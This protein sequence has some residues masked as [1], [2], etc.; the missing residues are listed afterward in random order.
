MFDLPGYRFLS[1]LHAGR[2]F[3]IDRG[4]RLIDD[5]PVIIKRLA[6]HARSEENLNRLQHEYNLLREL[7]IPGVVQP[8]EYRAEALEPAVVFA[9]PGGVPA[10]ELLLAR[11][12]S[13]HQWLPI[14]IHL[15]ETLGR[16]HR[17]GVIHRQLN[18][19][20]L[21][22]NPDTQT[23]TLVNFCLATGAG[24]EPVTGDLAPLS[25]KGLPYIAPEQTGRINRSVDY[26]TDFYSFGATLYQ[27]LSHAPPFSADDDLTLLHSHIARHPLP[28]HRL[29]PAL[30][31]VLSRITLKLLAKDN[32]QRYLSSFGLTQDLR[33][34]YRCWMETASIP[35]FS[36]AAQDI[37]ERFEIPQTLY[38]RESTIERLQQLLQRRALSGQGATTGQSRILTA[39]ELVLISGYA[40]VG[41]TSLVQEIQQSIQLHN[42]RFVRGKF[43]PFPSPYSGFLKALRSLIRQLLA[44]PEARVAQWRQKLDSTLGTQAP[45]MVQMLPELGLLMGDGQVGAGPNRPEDRHLPARLFRT[46]LQTFATAEQPLVLLLDDL[47][48]ADQASLNL[49]QALTQ[50][51][52]RPSLLLI[53]SYRDNEVPADHP[54]R[55]LLNALQR[56][57]VQITEIELQPLPL[58]QVTR[59][60]ADTLCCAPSACAG[61]AKICLDKTQGNPFFL[62][63]FLISLHDSGLIRFTGE[64]WHWDE[65]QIRE[66]AITDNVVDL[67]LQK[68]QRLTRQTRD[69]LQLAAGIGS[70]FDLHTLAVVSERSLQQA[71]KDLLP[72]LK[73]GLV[74]PLEEPLHLAREPGSGR[75]GYRFA[76]DRVHQAAYALVAAD[77]RQ[78]LHLQI[79]RMMQQNLNRAESD[80]RTFEITNHFNLARSLLSTHGE[81]L[82]LAHLNLKAG[83]RA[84]DAAAFDA[85]S[86][87]LQRGLDQ[88]PQGGWRSHYALT[89]ELHHAAIEVAYIRGDYAALEPLAAEVLSQAVDLLDQVPVYE[90]RI[91]SQVA[92]NQF[93][94]ALETALTVLRLLGVDLPESP[95]R[96]RTGA[97][98]MKIRW[99]LRRH[100]PTA[101]LGAARMKDRRMLAATSI[102]VSMFGAIKFSSSAL[103]TLVMAKQVELCLR[104][105]LTPVSAQVFAGYAGVLCGRV[106]TVEQGY[107]LG[108]LALQLDQREPS[109]SR[110]Q[111]TL[112]LF[113]TYVRH[114]KE[115]LRASCESLL[116]GY[117][118]AADNGDMEW[119]AYCL[120]A[121]IQFAFLQGGDL[122]GLQ[123]RFDEHV[124]WL[125]RSGQK[126][127]VQY[128]LFT[129]Q[130]IDNLRYPR[131][132]PTWLDG[133]YYQEDFMMAE[134]RAGNHRTAIC[135]HHFYKALLGYLFGEIDAAVAHCDA[136]RPYL[137]YIGG[138]YTFAFHPFLD[139]LC[140]LAQ[141]PGLPPRQ[142]GPALRRVRKGI[143]QLNNWARHCPHNHRHHL[144]LLQAELDAARGRGAAA[145]DRYDEAI[146]LARDNGFP[147]VEALANERAGV[148]HLHKDRTAVAAA[149]LNEARRC[150][151]QLGAEAKREQLEDA[152]PAVFVPDP[153]GA[154]HARAA[155]SERQPPHSA[156]LGFTNQTI[157]IA[158]V[159][160]ASQAISDEI[161]LERLLARLMKLV[162]ENVG[163]QRA[164]LVLKRDQRLWLEAEA[165]VDGEVRFFSGQ[166]LHTSDRLPVSLVQYVARTQETL[167]LD[168]SRHQDMLMQDSYI[169]QQRPCSLLCAPVVYQGNLS[170]VL[171]LENNDNRDVFQ[172]QRVQILHVLLAQAAISIENA[173][174]YQSL[175]QSEQ[176][177]RS[178]FEN[179]IEGIF[180]SSLEGRFISVNP[181]LAALLGYDSAPQ[182][183]T[184][185]K[186]IGQQCFADQNDLRQLRAALTRD[187]R[188][189]NFETR[190]SRIDGSPV[191]VSLSIRSVLDDGGALRYYEGSVTDISERRARDEAELAQKAAHLA[192]EKAEAA[193]QA[194]SQFLATMSH[195]I[196]TPMNGILGMAQLLKR[197]AL[198]EEQRAQV[199][200]LQQSGQAL[201][202]ILNDV[203][204]LAKIESGQ[205]ELENAP[206][207]LDDWL[208]EVDTILSPL[209]AA[210]GLAFSLDRPTEPI[211]PVTGDRR[212]LN[213]ILMNLGTNAIKFTEQ[214][215]IHLRVRFQQIHA[216]RLGLQVTV[217]DSGIG[218]PESV[219]GRI[220]QD[221]SQ[222]DSSITRR[223]GGTGLGLSICRQLV[224]LHQGRIG[225]ESQVG[226]GSRFWF[227]IDYPTCDPA[228]CNQ[229]TPPA[230]DYAQEP[231][232]PLRVLL[233]EDTQI[234][235]QVAK[236]LLAVDG[237]RVW[238]AA[239]GHQALALHRNQTF[240]LVLMDIHLPGMDGMETTRALRQHP[241]PHKA[242][243]PVIALTASMTTDE[244]KAYRAAGIDRVLGKPL[245]LD[246]LRQ[247]LNA[248]LPPQPASGVPPEPPVTAPLLSQTSQPS[249]PAQLPRRRASAGEPE[250]SLIDQALLAQHRNT[251]G[252][253]KFEALLAT[254][255]RQCQELFSGLDSALAANDRAGLCGLAHKLAGAGANFGLRALAER[256]KEIEASASNAKT[257]RLA[258]KISQA[259][260]VYRT[261]RAQL[262]RAGALTAEA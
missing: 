109:P 63:Q 47:H 8:L 104:H 69:A 1:Q 60:V 144:V 126:Q 23:A 88:L 253:E 84:R 168:D 166:S 97:G 116:R 235:Q 241:D 252:A 123:Q 200:T 94:A 210:K 113:D 238:T 250:Q 147:L 4:L 28:P 79:A 55:S 46:L 114:W 129:L 206:F 105:G 20:N 186:D 256:C 72:A 159:V 34:C 234:N 260:E 190:W 140:R 111:R 150:Y 7:E 78:T 213:Q 73:E 222:A 215:G 10:S 45:L 244:V 107:A 243:I 201:L 133:K 130:V 204:D 92:R 67:L 183:L 172:A 56:A 192:R 181:A 41:K 223:Y 86:D 96:Q 197:G 164:L 233:V 175:T 169:K 248:A 134:H 184:A 167:L 127:S 12:C 179:A 22:I 236:A 19:S 145:I 209:A 36:I 228:L 124:K 101:I 90:V 76:H 163:A 30:P 143:R 49:I 125:R 68:M 93:S 70:Q 198:S 103:R 48:W 26:R 246:A 177:F 24:D 61:L 139:G 158:S 43:D 138:T 118:L 71:A 121:H 249:Q 149:Y 106:K 226:K 156:P 54:L 89:L 59:L 208:D 137:P 254:L 11:R 25:S 131:P 229:P 108:Q 154:A 53:A 212:S 39:Q 195:E 29:N 74:A 237:H 66:Q 230:Q 257:S 112:Y 196:R 35:L 194:K 171:Y 153:M 6:P 32:A 231:V 98:V 50:G 152:H 117:R 17:A 33:H 161:V 170:A 87:Y 165:E 202:G 42:G 81:R 180:R 214:G 141:L 27:M 119:G 157:D 239:D 15:S 58:P 189:R 75:Q 227:E 173:T 146:A 259:R 242:A 65:A 13:W 52:Q 245:L 14:V 57:P 38:G 120:A 37:S 142:R 182:F 207:H 77:Q 224:E 135:L 9:D 199:D 220:F 255:D 240:D 122:S 221:F 31:E 151:R 162:I 232:R 83:R 44:E 115:P 132:H 185:I 217:A 21:L 258:E 18:P 178:L 176:E 188:V 51:G 128:S 64:R 40:G 225:Y 216:G 85:A 219:R 251:L 136:A 99:L 155:H 2:S 203:L 218:I 160:K 247:V 261:S 205:L 102:L 80:N 110:H 148:Y 174:L 16:L 3:I 82:Q 262:E 62:R 95:S 91:Q 187:R 191:Y 211:P 5:Q 193:N 100:P